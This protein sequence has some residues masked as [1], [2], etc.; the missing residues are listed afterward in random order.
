MVRPC[1]GLRLSQFECRSRSVVRFTTARVPT[2]WARAS[3]CRAT[4]RGSAPGMHRAGGVCS[5]AC[6]Y[7]GVA[8]IVGSRARM[9]VAP[10]AAPRRPPRPN[11]HP[12]IASIPAAGT[13]T[14][15]APLTG[16]AFSCTLSAGRRGRRLNLPICN[17][18][19]VIRCTAGVPLKSVM[20]RGD[21]AG[22]PGPAASG[23]RRAVP[24]GGAAV[25]WQPA[26]DRSP[27]VPAFA[28]VS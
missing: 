1:T 20:S 18:E 2:R 10:S 13:A 28:V 8:T 6:T 12:G 27:S 26:P 21:R 25:M 23:H 14:C 7:D 17:D 24:A 22:G 3:L 15:R 11:S 19:C 9:I 4:P 16:S 5:G